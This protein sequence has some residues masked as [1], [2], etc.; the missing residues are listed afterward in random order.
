MISRTTMRGGR[1]S[2]RYEGRRLLAARPRRS[3]RAALTAGE[4]QQTAMKRNTLL[5]HRL[6]QQP[7]LVKTWVAI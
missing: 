7:L 2:Y 1:P 3:T 6:K 4:Q 5:C